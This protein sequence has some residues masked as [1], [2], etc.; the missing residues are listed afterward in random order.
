MG[1]CFPLNVAPRKQNPHPTRWGPHMNI[2]EMALRGSRVARAASKR[3][4]KDISIVLH[5]EQHPDEWVAWTAVRQTIRN[6]VL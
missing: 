6:L 1:H 4:E 5:M 3:P 2:Q